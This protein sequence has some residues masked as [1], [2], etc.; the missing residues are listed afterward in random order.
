METDISSNYKERHRPFWLILLAA[1][2]QISAAEPKPAAGE[3]P[4][5]KP[6]EP[7][8]ALKA[9]Q[10]RDGFRMELVAAEPLVADPMALAFDERGRL[11]VVEMHGYPEKRHQKIGKVRLLT[12]TDGDGVFD[13]STVFAKDLGWPSAVIAYDGGV[14]IGC[15]PDIYFMRDNDG[16][17]IADEK[18]TAFTGFRTGSP[19]EI[20]PRLF[21]SF[22]W[23]YDNRIY[24]ASSMNGGI[25]RRPD[26]PESEAINLTRDDFSFDPKTFDLRRESGTAQHGMSFDLRGIR[27]ASRNSNHI[28]AMVYDSRYANLNPDYTMPNWRADIAVEGPA[29]KVYRISPPEPWRILRTRWRVG[30]KI[31]G[32][33]EGG[34]T[35]FGYFT[36][37]T[38]VTI[39]RGDAYPRTFVGNAFIGAPA[40]NLIHRK[41][42][43][44]QG[45]AP[46]ARRA[47]PERKAEFVAST[48]NW[49]RPVQ[50]VNG[51]DGCL[52]VADMYRETIEVA[53]AIPESIKAH[54]D[55]YSG[56]DRGRIYRITWGHADRRKIPNFS[57]MK[58]EQLVATLSHANGWHRDTA[59]RLLFENASDKIIPL[60]RNALS[61]SHSSPARIHVL[62]LLERMGELSDEDLMAK[63]KDRDA[64]IREHVLR[65][66]ANRLVNMSDAPLLEAASLL[67]NDPDAR[68]KMQLAMTLGA[69]KSKT[70]S[71]ILA[72]LAKDTDG[73]RWID[74][75]VLNSAGGRLGEFLQFVVAGNV[76]HKPFSVSA[77]TAKA[78]E[79]AAQTSDEKGVEAA[80]WLLERGA[81]AGD[82]YRTAT[83]LATGLR[84]ARSDFATI[85]AGPV[86][87]ALLQQAKAD[88]RNPSSTARTEA[89]DCL[90]FGEFARVKAVLF[91]LLERSEPLPVQ[92]AA[93]RVLD[94][95]TSA[96]ISK[97][98]VD[99]WTVLTP[100]LRNEAVRVILRRT[101]HTIAFLKAIDSRTI[102]SSAIPFNRRNALRRHRDKQ[103]QALAKKIF[104][105]RAGVS[106]NEA[107]EKYRDSLQLQGDSDEGLVVYEERC[108]TC[109]VFKGKGHTL[110]PDLESIRA[111]TAEEILLHVLNPNLKVE[112]NQRGYTIETTEDESLTG[113]IE[114]ESVNSVSLRMPNGLSRNVLR[115]HITELRSSG[116]SIMPEGLEENLS[117]QSMAD[118][119]AFLKN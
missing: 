52:Y 114:S 11:Y 99:R 44:L 85:G 48:D 105:S 9:F 101:G 45:A 18:R 27:Y 20:A 74:G 33:I 43:N 117:L 34:G 47:D 59:A 65:L 72:A 102:N 23:G 50:F 4:R 91:G 100:T 58:P 8:E 14:F 3:M 41:T 77:V 64:G 36:S 57:S 69:S 29:A 1:A 31:S 104:G 56:T 49:F 79:L 32:P 115:T 70:A 110:G 7:A 38:G 24:A 118:L 98:L 76:H 40:N 51:P 94:Q 92:M 61:N 17:G 55:I 81:T 22:R 83:A 112:P 88:A 84:R 78:I 68:V 103:V 12:D 19:R 96:E 95:F 119:I 60:L 106:R 80:V 107:V 82:K 67:I 97:Q 46:V 66:V 10:V 2:L 15:A 75:A 35:A 90:A 21:N 73:D 30:G 89:I 25:V 113:I 6:L 116:M 109:H 13:K 71:A 5:L 26:Q 86:S 54:M 93:I 37:A 53:H 39:Y 108:Q 62:Y 16:D 111:W 42:I 63:L 87:Q 28:M